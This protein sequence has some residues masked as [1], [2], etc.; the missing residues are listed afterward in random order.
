MS[1]PITL[2]VIQSYLAAVAREMQTNI[3]R[4]GYSTAVR[5]S[6]DAS[7]ALL[8]PE[9]NV[10]GEHVVLPLHMGTFPVVVRRILEAYPPAEL[11]EGDAFITNHPYLC[12]LPHTSDMAVVTP[13][14]Y[15]GRLLGFAATIA[16]KTDLGGLAPGGGSAQARELFHEGTL[17]PP[18]RWARAGEELPEV[19]VVLAANSRTPDQVVGDVRGQVGTCR[20][21]ERRV[22]ELCAKY[23][24]DLVQAACAA[25]QRQTEQRL[26]AELRRWPD[27]VYE[28]ERAMD[29]DGCDLDRPVRVHVRIA[30][31]GDRIQFDFRGCH[32]QTRGPANLRPPLVRACCGYVL[33]ALID[34]TL[35]NN[36]GVARV[37]E[38]VFAAG[39]LLDPVYPAPVNNYIPAAS[40]VI[41]TCLAALAPV[42]PDRAIAGPGGDGG[43]YLRG[44]DAAGQPFVLYEVQGSAYGGRAG[45][46]GVSCVCTYVS[47]CRITPIEI[48]ESEFP[49]RVTRFEPI[50]DSGGPGRYRG[51][52]AYRR[53]FEVLAPEARFSLR[54]GRHVV[55][56]AGLFGGGPGRLGRCVVRRAN[57][58][59]VR[60]PSRVG[61]FPL[62]RGDRVLIEKAGAGGYGDPRTRPPEAVRED[63]LN[64]YVS[65][66]AARAVY[67][68]VDDGSASSVPEAWRQGGS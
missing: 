42:V 59:E 62:R 66:E 4:T 34:P 18:V 5:E 39:T 37:V 63:V 43:I 14:F 10:V 28:A 56:A 67:G 3:F 32:P 48:I 9:G 29:H 21:G 60:L 7:C 50:T 13:I 23:G 57:G 6:Q 33:L 36:G 55:P 31:R 40:L 44:V 61:E 16:H 58:E 27:G 24:P 49:L 8:D 30:K 64:G 22:Q 65:L 12:G 17:V 19:R 46:D 41:E 45:A 2:Q 1:D 51:G 47:N 38:T 25:A 20:L 54:G 11:R 15:A 26:R 52:L 35:P 53:E 68:L